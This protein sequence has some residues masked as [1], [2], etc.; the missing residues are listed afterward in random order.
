VSLSS[1]NTL[2][3]AVEFAHKKG[4]AANNAKLLLFEFLPRMPK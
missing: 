4:S 3:V 2:Q 1:K